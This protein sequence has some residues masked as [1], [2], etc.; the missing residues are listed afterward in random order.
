[1]LAG[2]GFGWRVLG[3]VGWMGAVRHFGGGGGVGWRRLAAGGWLMETSWGWRGAGW[4]LAGW[5]GSVGWRGLWLE[6]VLGGVGW[7]GAVGC[8]GGRL[9]VEGGLARRVFWGGLGGEG[10]LAGGCGRGWLE[11]WLGWGLERGRFEGG[12]G[13]GD[14]L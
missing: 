6:G 7:M 5:R 14:W 11:G 4:R 13:L 8:G 3:G 2:G 9:A 10:V 12:G 1:M